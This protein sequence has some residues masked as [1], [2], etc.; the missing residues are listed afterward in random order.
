MTAREERNEG[1]LDGLLLSFE[2]AFYSLPQ[3]LNER[4]LVLEH[5]RS[6][7]HAHENSTGFPGDVPSALAR[8]SRHLLGFSMGDKV[9]ARM[10]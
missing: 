8:K 7:R 5:G 1:Q 10:R 2:S 6:S 4:E 9:G 3:I